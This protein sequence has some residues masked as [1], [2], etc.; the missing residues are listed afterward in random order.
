MS[1]ARYA[2][3]A[4]QLLL[5]ERELRALNLWSTLSPSAEALASVQPF[6]V[7]SMDFEMWLQWVLLP[8]IAHC[9]EHGAQLPKGSGICAMGEVVFAQRSIKAQRLLLELE[10][11][12]RLLS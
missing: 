9:I 6:C 5:I 10:R 1:Q 4:E 2:A 8:R 3:L 7:D 12:D 11:F